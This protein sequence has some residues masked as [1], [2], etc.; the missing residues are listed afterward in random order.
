MAIFLNNQYAEYDLEMTDPDL[1]DK[2]EDFPG[3][4]NDIGEFLDQDNSKIN[5]HPV[6]Q[7]IINHYGKNN[8]S[9]SELNL[10]E[11]D[12]GG[13]LIFPNKIGCSIDRACLDDNNAAD[14]KNKTLEESFSNGDYSLEGL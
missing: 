11:Q 1:N 4:I 7:H 9:T 6:I 14:A 8:H 5:D 13:K 12:E 3:N 2:N 10:K